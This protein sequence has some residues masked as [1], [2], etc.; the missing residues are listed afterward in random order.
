VTLLIQKPQIVNDRKTNGSVYFTYSN[1]PRLI[2]WLGLNACKSIVPNRAQGA[3]DTK[4]Q[5]INPCKMMVVTEGHTPL[6][7]P[8]KITGRRCEDGMKFMYR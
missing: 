1:G 3:T 7:G 2:L 5:M 4:A 8:L 6:G